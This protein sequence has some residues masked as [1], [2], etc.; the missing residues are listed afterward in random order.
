[1]V[2]D[3]VR[4]TE[5]ACARVRRASR[6]DMGEN[7]PSGNGRVSIWNRAENR[8]ISGSAAP[9]ARN[10]ES[11]LK[12]HPTCEVYNGQMK[13]DAPYKERAIRPADPIV[14]GGAASVAMDSGRTLSEAGAAGPQA[15]GAP[16][17]SVVLVPVHPSQRVPQPVPIPIQSNQGVVHH[18]YPRCTFSVP[19]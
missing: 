1:M 6:C 2:S 13:Q 12:S 3:S 10:L 9:L 5:E 11:Y 14:G 4:G 19:P 8:R 16:R 7:T 18:V 15:L 17:G